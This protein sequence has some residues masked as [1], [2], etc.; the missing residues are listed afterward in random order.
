MRVSGGD[1]T[2]FQ[3]LKRGGTL[4]EAIYAPEDVC[5]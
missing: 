4:R 5:S 3:N 2:N 1:K